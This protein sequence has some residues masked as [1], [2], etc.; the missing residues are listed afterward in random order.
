MASEAEQSWLDHF[1]KTGSEIAAVE[2][3]FPNVGKEAKDPKAAKAVRASQLKKK[4][5][6]DISERLNTRLIYGAHDMLNIVNALAR[7]SGTDSVRLAACKDWLDRSQVGT[8]KDQQHTGIQV[9]I[10]RSGVTINV[11]QP[12]NKQDTDDTIDAIEGEG[13]AISDDIS[14][15]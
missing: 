15:E 3:A 5:T 9:M 11:S 4:L 14:N 13:E 6:P 2:Y 8:V 12:S 1:L 7:E 10:N